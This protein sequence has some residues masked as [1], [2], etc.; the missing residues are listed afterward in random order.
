MLIF[1]D[2]KLTI[3]KPGTVRFEGKFIP[4]RVRILNFVTELGLAR[5]TIRRRFG[6]F[7][8]SRDL[9]ESTRQRLRN[10]F[11]AECPLKD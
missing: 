6:R 3:L 2:A 9:D 8:F 11:A 7:I 5:G 10:F 1:S 4:H